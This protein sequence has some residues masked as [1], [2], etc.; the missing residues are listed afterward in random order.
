MKK[1]AKYN[2]TYKDNFGKTA[3]IIE[4]DFKNLFT[5]IDGVKFS[6][7]E[8]AD[9]I[10]FDKTKYTSEQLKR[11][12]FFETPIYNTD[13]VEKALCNCIFEISIPQLII[14][15][16]DY[17]EFYSDLKVE[18]SLGNAEPKP[19]GGLEFEEI[20]LSITIDEKTYIGTSDLI[21]SAFDQIRDQFEDK[22]QF[23]NC[24]GCMFGD[25][26][27]FGQSGFGTM[28]C[29]VSQKE[30]YIKVTNKSEYMELPTEKICCVQEIY[31]CDHYEIR[32]KRAGYRG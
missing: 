27:V 17:S 29:F 13:I 26:S 18:Y 11:F 22:Y 25:Y 28:L 19:K 1:Q 7:S 24:Y 14:D 10:V 6:G 16:T 20:K 3:I 8:F 30:K 21:E 12:T 4:N 32:T 5:E 15:K 31:G 9:L 2:G 23:K